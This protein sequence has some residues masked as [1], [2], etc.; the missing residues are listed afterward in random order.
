MQYDLLRAVCLP[1]VQDLFLH[2]VMS[3]TS[4]TLESL[5]NDFVLCSY[6]CEKNTQIARIAYTRKKEKRGVG[7]LGLVF[8][9]VNF[10]SL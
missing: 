4:E 6:G 3:V 7:R 9:M 8:N 5:L 2:L 1:H 10:C